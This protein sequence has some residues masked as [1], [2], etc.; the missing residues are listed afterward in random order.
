MIYKNG[1]RTRDFF[2]P[3]CFYFILFALASWLVRSFPERAVRI[4]GV[5]RD[6]VLCSWARPFTL[7]VPLSTQEY[8]WVAVNCWGKPNK[9]LGE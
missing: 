1:E 6:T 2:G 4:Q 5:V 9:L 7:T 8:K 3:F